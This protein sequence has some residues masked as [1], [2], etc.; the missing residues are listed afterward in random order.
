M[1]IIQNGERRVYDVHRVNWEIREIRNRISLIE[2]QIKAM[3]R[4]MDFEGSA[5]CWNIMRSIEEAKVEKQAL[6]M[7]LRDVLARR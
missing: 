5:Q 2:D 4:F 1:V 3:G 7:S 6:K